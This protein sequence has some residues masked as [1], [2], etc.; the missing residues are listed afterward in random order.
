MGP[1]C[2]ITLLSCVT[3]CLAHS[4]RLVVT[5]L[6]PEE[7]LLSRECTPSNTTL[8]K[9]Y[10]RR[11]VIDMGREAELMLDQPSL[12]QAYEKCALNVTNVE[13]DLLVASVGMMLTNSEPLST[14]LWHYADDEPYSMQMEWVWHNR[15]FLGDPNVTVGV[16]DTGLAQEA[17]DPG[18][19]AHMADGYDFIS[20]SGVSSDGDG[21]DPIAVDPGG[22]ISADCPVPFHG[23]MMANL[24]AGADPNAPGMQPLSTLLPIRVLGACGM[25]Y[26][27]D[28]ADGIVWAVGGTINGIES[29]PKP[30]QVLSMSFSGAGPCPSYLQS[31]I[32]TAVTRG[33]ILVA[34]SGNDGADAL[35]GHFPANCVG[36]V[37]VGASTRRGTL[38]AYSNRGDL[39]AAAPGGDPTDP[40][41]S[42]AANAS[43]LTLASGYGTSFSTAL[44]SGLFALKLAMPALNTSLS[45]LFFDGE[46]NPFTS[47]E[48]GGCG[49]GI[50]SGL[51]LVTS[52]GLA[53]AGLNDTS[54]D[55]NGILNAQRATVKAA[56]LA[57]NCAAGSYGYGIDQ[58]TTIQN[59]SRTVLGICNGDKNL[60]TGPTSCSYSASTAGT[61]SV[62]GTLNGNAIPSGVQLWNVS[63][64][65]TYLLVATGAAG[66]SY[67]TYTQAMVLW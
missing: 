67:S 65:G 31:A 2:I 3:L 21:R 25:G 6:N 55:F 34:A 57:G 32:L 17:L 24:I 49:P 43:G 8:V 4:N 63:T 66:A 52:S 54:M 38:A 56:A 50:E 26:A 12:I 41:W 48:G 10:G 44:T 7:A 23:T 39:M 11:A 46:F 28:V 62:S 45:R 60:G 14:A 20:D 16:L 33:T 22:V 15:S 61:F 36:V 9:Q 27:N 29:N 47:C 35:A 42:V 18:L 64:T 5:F 37:P 58:C 53:I 1:L 59:P 51:L 30:A 40:V 13:V 19:F